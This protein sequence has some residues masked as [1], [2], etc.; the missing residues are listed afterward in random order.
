MRKKNKTPVDVFIM[1][2]IM[3]LLV[4]AIF[5][6]NILWK[7][8]IEWKELALDLM[9]SLLSAIVVGF[10]I[11]TFTKIITD[12][13]VAIQKNNKR[14]ASFG[15]EEISTGVSSKRDCTEL[16][17]NG[18]LNDYPKEIKL[19]FVTGNGFMAHFESDLV[20]AISCGDCDVKILIASISAENESFL[21]RMEA[22][23][24]Q[25]TTYRDQIMKETLPIVDRIRITVGD[26]KK[27]SVRFYN[28]EYRNNY[29]IAKYVSKDHSVE[30]KYWLNV[31]TPTLDAVDMS[32]VLKGRTDCDTVASEN[33]F[34]QLDIGFDLLWEKYQNTQY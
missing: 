4:A 32:V 12:R 27:I 34:E 15:I 30:G 10:V 7:T 31:Q 25:K 5:F 21:K 29:R 2:G 11:S 6:F 24:P 8:Q 28:D 33:L 17:G 16:F 18:L 14:L 1:L 19:L 13:F 9:N 20:R 22:I 26:P 23:C 3:L